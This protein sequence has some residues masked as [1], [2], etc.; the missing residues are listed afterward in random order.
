MKRECAAVQAGK[1]PD[2]SA[3]ASA[4]ERLSGSAAPPNVIAIGATGR[5]CPSYRS[6]SVTD[7][8]LGPSVFRV[9]KLAQ[10]KIIYT[11]PKASYIAALS[12][13][14]Y[15]L[16]GATRSIYSTVVEDQINNYIDQLGTEWRALH[17]FNEDCGSGM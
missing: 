15:L 3:S 1:S 11:C 7:L 4:R 2:R 13:R 17:E 10:W 5:R 6:T 8:G 9:W 12:Y 14:A 16:S